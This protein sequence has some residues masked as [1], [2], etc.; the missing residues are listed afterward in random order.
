MFHLFFSF[1]SIE[2]EWVNEEWIHL[3]QMKMG[4]SCRYS[5]SFFIHYFIS[6]HFFH[7][8]R[9][10]LVAEREKE[11]EEEM[12]WITFNNSNHSANEIN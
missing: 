9:K 8:F 3:N 2:F 11:I 6:I 5:S 4:Y 1:I 7:F 12:K 10:Q